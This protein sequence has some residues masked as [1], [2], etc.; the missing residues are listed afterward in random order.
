MSK[1]LKADW[2]EWLRRVCASA[3]LR[4]SRLKE[5]VAKL[6]RIILALFIIPSQAFA[7]AQSTAKPQCVEDKVFFERAVQRIWEKEARGYLYQEGAMT[8]D[9][10]L[11]HEML[12]RHLISHKTPQD[13]LAQNPDCCSLEIPPCCF[14]EAFEGFWNFAPFYA[15]YPIRR[16]NTAVVTVR[17]RTHVAAEGRAAWFYARHRVL[18]GRCGEALKIGRF[19]I[20]TTGAAQEIE[21]KS[22]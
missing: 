15:T 11:P 18:L 5:G 21:R 9:R 8:F 13:F 14:E 6:C 16:D 4:A 10:L 19:E 17:Y 20:E 7:Q 1:T 2:L 22:K 12:R 3:R